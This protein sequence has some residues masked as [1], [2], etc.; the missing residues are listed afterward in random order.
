MPLLQQINPAQLPVV[1]CGAI[2]RRLTPCGHS[3]SDR[4]TLNPFKDVVLC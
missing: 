1:V 2:V 4:Q 3:S